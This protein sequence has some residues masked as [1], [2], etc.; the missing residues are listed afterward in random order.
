MKILSALLLFLMMLPVSAG[1]A[2]THKYGPYYGK[3][4]DAET[5]EPIEGAAVLVVYYTEQYGLA[6]SVVQFA[7]AQETLTDKNGEFKI[8]AIRI[9][10]FRIISGWEKYPDVRIFKP[11]YG[12]YPKHKDV[13]PVFEYGSLPSNQYVTIELPN[14]K[15]EP[16][17]KRLDNAACLPG[18]SVPDEKYKRLRRLIEEE[19]KSVGY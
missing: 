8:P 13:K 2:I 19:Y 1:C 14:I 7:D 18:P 11:G 17:E 9:N 12:C 6:G 10:K 16:I 3:I 15:N 5:K 4:I